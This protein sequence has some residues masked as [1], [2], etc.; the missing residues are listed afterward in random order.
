MWLRLEPLT[1]NPNPMHGSAG[2]VVGLA[3][4]GP[5]VV[6]LL[7]LPHVAPYCAALAP[8]LAPPAGQRASPRAIEAAHVFNALGAAAAAAVA[9]LAR[10][11]CA[12][13]GSHNTVHGAA[14]QG[15]RVL[16]QSLLR[17]GCLWSCKS[18]VFLAKDSGTSRTVTLAAHTSSACSCLCSI[19]HRCGARS[20]RLSG[21]LTH[22]AW[23][24]AV[25]Y[26]ANRVYVCL[27]FID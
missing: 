24:C 18:L 11:W 26:R 15:F 27:T 21:S 16:P 14:Q 9:D 4:L 1:T 5:R 2:A 25:L 19:R 10:A 8:A 12:C 20:G 3:A 17:V 6:R 13:S 23:Y 7:L 22:N